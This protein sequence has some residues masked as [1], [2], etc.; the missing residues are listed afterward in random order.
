MR[1]SRWTVALYMGI[2]FLCGGIVGAFGFRLY[3]VSG[4]SANVAPR[5]PDEFRKKYLA[6][7]KPRLHLSDDQISKMNAIMDV[8]RMRFRETRESI[9][10]E[11]T[12]IREDQ[13]RQFADLFSPDQ[14]VEWQKILAERQRERENKKRNGIP[15]APPPSA[16]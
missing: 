2:V 9:E 1:L 7:I 14:K 8:T 5:N 10:P 6:D 12:K 3:S 11:L 4:V 16:R 15:Q 13:Q